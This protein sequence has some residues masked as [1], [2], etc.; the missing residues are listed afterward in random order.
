MSKLILKIK[1][2][3]WEKA[4]SHDIE[5]FTNGI[6]KV[7]SNCFP[8]FRKGNLQPVL[9]PT[10]LG[11]GTI[12]PTLPIKKIFPIFDSTQKFYVWQG[13]GTNGPASQL[14]VTDGAS[15]TNVTAQIASGTY[16]PREMSIWQNKLIYIKDT[17]ARANVVP[18]SAGSDVQVLSGLTSTGALGTPHPG[19]VGAD[20]YYYIGNG[21]NV[22]KLVIA[23]GTLG[24]S[25][26]VAT[27]LESGYTVRQLINDGR[28]L[29][30]IADNAQALTNSQFKNSCV[31]AFWDMAKAVFDQVYE[32]TDSYITSGELIGDIIKI[33]TPSGIYHCNIATRP[34][35]IV[36]FDTASR[37]ILN[38]E[39]PT[40]HKCTAVW[41][42]NFLLWGSQKS[43]GNDAIYAYGNNT[44]GNTDRLINPF[45]VTSNPITAIGTDN[46]SVLAG[47]GNSGSVKLY[48]MNNAGSNETSVANVAGT[49]LDQP[50][51][52]DFAKVVTRS[53]ISSGASVSLKILNGAS[54]TSTGTKSIKSSETKTN[55]TDPGEKNLIFKHTSLDDGTDVKAFDEI[56]D[57]ELTTNVPIKEM[58]IWGTPEDPESSY[59]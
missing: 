34:R 8:F 31:V 25:T 22:A 43:T 48:I 4:L 16:T 39:I 2:T 23:T 37:S 50:Y 29:V 18:V 40:D 47:V 9:A 26:A 45:T 56:S 17:E 10:E 57:I 49:V 12:S 32:F 41:K 13:D 35:L 42:Q 33:I 1:S 3:D 59:G 14:H 24:N 30:W 28:Y 21:N 20:R 55:S 54:S 5:T 6:F 36:P 58:E 7:F 15:V 52:F 46:N 51:T 38:S 19:C 44:V 11:F 53:P 27:S